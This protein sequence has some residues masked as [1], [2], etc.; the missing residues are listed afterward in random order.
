MHNVC[1]PLCKVNHDCEVYTYQLDAAHDQFCSLSPYARTSVTPEIQVSNFGLLS[2]PIGDDISLSC[3][4]D[5]GVGDGVL[6]VVSVPLVVGA[7]LV[8]VVKDS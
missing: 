6:V 7:L 8:I 3:I 4:G 2:P 5:T 1:R